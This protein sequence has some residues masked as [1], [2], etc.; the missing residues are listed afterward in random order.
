MKRHCGKHNQIY[1]AIF[2]KFTSWVT[3]EDIFP[4]FGERHLQKTMSVTFNV[5][6]NK[7]VNSGTKI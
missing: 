6:E 7:S 2:I 4:T 3:A 5:K 1:I